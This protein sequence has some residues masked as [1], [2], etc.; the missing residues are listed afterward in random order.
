CG[1]VFK[2]YHA[3]HVRAFADDFTALFESP[4]DALSAA[5]EIHRR[6]RTY[7]R[8]QNSDR[9]A[10]ECGIGIGYGDV[11]TI[12]IDRAMGDEMNRSSKLGEDTARGNEV[13][14]TENVFASLRNR[15]DCE[16]QRR[17]FEEIPFPFY[18]VFQHQS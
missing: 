5:F 1:P 11:Y 18:E 15:E 9:Q 2:E 17:V 6:I 8:T 16:F 7:N 4:D 13:L 3:Y 12:G 10:A 14:V